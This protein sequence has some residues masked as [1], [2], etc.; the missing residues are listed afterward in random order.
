MCPIT[1]DDGRSLEQIDTEESGERAVEGTMRRRCPRY[2]VWMFD[3]RDASAAS[4]VAL[5]QTTISSRVSVNPQEFVG[6]TEREFQILAS[7][8]FPR[9][10]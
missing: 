7:Q 9:E 2:T 6:R 5:V 1:F 3:D 8:V 10:R 4:S